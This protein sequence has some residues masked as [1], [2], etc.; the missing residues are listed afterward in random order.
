MAE[1]QD[2]KTGSEEQQRTDQRDQEPESALGGGTAT[3]S[4]TKTGPDTVEQSDR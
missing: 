1:K 2:T 4:S 3:R